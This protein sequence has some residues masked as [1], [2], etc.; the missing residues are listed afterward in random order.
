MGT[1]ESAWVG[2]SVCVRERVYVYGRE[3]MCMIADARGA[4]LK[5]VYVKKST[6]GRTP[7]YIS[8]N[9]RVPIISH[10]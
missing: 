8:N 7:V 9:T 10:M 5:L 4:W 3:C 1:G 2:E 6:C